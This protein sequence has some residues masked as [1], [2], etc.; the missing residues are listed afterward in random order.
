[1]GL[2]WRL[3]GRGCRPLPLCMNEESRSG[4]CLSMDME[5]AVQSREKEKSRTKGF[6]SGNS[7]Q[8]DW[9][10][11]EG[12][13]VGLSQGLK[14]TLKAEAGVL[15][16]L[17]SSSRVAR[18]LSLCKADG[19]DTARVDVDVDWGGLATPGST[20]EPWTLSNSHILLV[21]SLILRDKNIEHFGVL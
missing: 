3:K 21:S 19:V 13:N 5:E 17:S 2:Q 9:G 18:G 10:R 20:P 1:M 7:G 15:A 16:R 4:S 6:M 8:Q 12:G 14:V 11:R